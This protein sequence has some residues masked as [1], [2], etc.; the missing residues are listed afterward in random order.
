MA[1]VYRC[2]YLNH[3][4]ALLK[5]QEHQQ[6][7]PSLFPDTCTT[8]KMCAMKI[9]LAILHPNASKPI[10]KITERLICQ[11][12]GEGGE[13]ALLLA[14]PGGSFSVRCTWSCRQPQREW[15]AAPI[16]GVR[17]SHGCNPEFPNWAKLMPVSLAAATVG[18]IIRICFLNDL[19]A[20][21]S[22]SC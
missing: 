8:N 21:K 17:S 14:H 6:V 18:S 5:L 11:E 10:Q 16:W 2:V 20:C 22:E 3:N 15:G 4:T 9:I 1:A 19:S 7:T 13:P 12:V